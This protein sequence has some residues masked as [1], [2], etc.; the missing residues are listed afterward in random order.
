MPNDQ[1]IDVRLAAT[2]IKALHVQHEAFMAAVGGWTADDVGHVR[3][4][5]GGLE[6]LCLGERFC[7][8]PRWVT[9][10]GTFHATEYALR[11]VDDP[12]G[13]PIWTFY[14]RGDMLCTTPSQGD[15]IITMSHPVAQK[16]MLY[17]IG[18]ALLAS[19][20]FLPLVG[21]KA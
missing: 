15:V 16:T 9:H 4:V 20:R 6:V 2:A 1:G 5:D 7:A 12:E 11:P 14:L 18:N 19:G 21:S 3:C 13:D 17:A 10:E 8:G